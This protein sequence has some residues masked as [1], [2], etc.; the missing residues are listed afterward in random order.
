MRSSTVLAALAAVACG[1]PAGSLAFAAT[2]AEPVRITIHTDQGDVRAELFSALAPE[3][4][5][6]FLARAKGAPAV[7]DPAVGAAAVGD[8]AVAAY[9][10]T[11]VCETRGSVHVVFGCQPFENS[12]PKPHAAKLG[13][14]APDE[15]DGRAMGLGA[16]I[17]N[18]MKTV[19][20]LWQL[21]VFPRYTQLSDSGKVVPARLAHM[22]DEFLHKGSDAEDMLLG[23]TK[24][25]YLEAMGFTYHDGLSPLRVTKGSLATFTM[26]PGDADERFLVALDD[27][28]ERDGRATVF[29]RVVEGWD[30]LDRIQR[31]PT[32][33]A[34][35]P[36][37]PVRITGVSID[38]DAGGASPA[39]TGER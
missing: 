32:D 26:W 6:L 15:I 4:V 30:V 22:F 20:A 24:L 23:K 1:V 16:Q 37:T 12:G 21:E 36:E 10:G 18:D 13:P 3:T 34:R 2:R 8:P 14:Q 25:F 27:L 11:Q 9:A 33:K 31:I 39:P 17:L 29:G 38:D 7:S 5:R 19:H 28:T 35:R